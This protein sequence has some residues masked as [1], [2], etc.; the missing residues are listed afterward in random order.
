MREREKNVH[1]TR[2]DSGGQVIENSINDTVE[3]THVAREVIIRTKLC[4]VKL[5]RERER[6]GDE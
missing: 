6:K 4:L 3:A 5:E 2:I 1:W